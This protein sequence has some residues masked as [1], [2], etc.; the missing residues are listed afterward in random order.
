MFC[1]VIP[2]SLPYHNRDTHASGHTGIPDLDVPFDKIVK[3]LGLPLKVIE[4]L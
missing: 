1:I 4:K 3:A 2:L